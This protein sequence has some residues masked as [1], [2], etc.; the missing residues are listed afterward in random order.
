MSASAFRIEA[1]VSDFKHPLRS[2]HPQFRSVSAVRAMPGYIAA[3]KVTVRNYLDVVD[4]DLAVLT[5]SRPLDLAGNDARA[6]YLPTAATP[7]P[8]RVARLVMAGF[9]SQDRNARNGTVNEIVKSTVRK[10][11]GSSQVLCMWLTTDTCWGD[12]GLG[13]V[14]PGARPTVV[15]IFSEAQTICSPGFAY[16]AFLDSPVALRFLKASG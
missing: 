9:G 5:L 6:A 16:Y 1:G 11:C 3:S 10:T 15:G 12:S 2:D 7:K 8:W 14:E 4:H 13:A